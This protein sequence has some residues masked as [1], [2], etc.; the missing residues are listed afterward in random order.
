MTD[1]K[2]TQ[3]K[4]LAEADPEVAQLLAQEE[5]RQ[6]SG[7]ELI[8]SEVRNAHGALR[9]A[10]TARSHCGLGVASPVR[11]HA[12][13][14][15]FA[16]LHFARCDGGARHCVHQ[17]ILRGPAQYVRGAGTALAGLR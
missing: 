17:Q 7:L 13:C 15:A 16:E 10:S 4:T 8:A 14:V 9:T 5:H 3:S 11:V 6:F 12:P 1:A 2:Q